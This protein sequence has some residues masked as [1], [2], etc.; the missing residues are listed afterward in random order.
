MRAP[1]N[2]GPDIIEVKPFTFKRVSARS[3]VAEYG[4]IGVQL[5]VNPSG[6]MYQAAGPVPASTGASVIPRAARIRLG[7]EGHGLSPQPTPEEAVNDLLLLL[8]EF[9]E[10]VGN[11]ALMGRKLATDQRLRS[12]GVGR[13]IIEGDTQFS[14]SSIAIAALTHTPTEIE[15]END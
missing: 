8:H 10:H 1:R 9:T 4:G 15:I 3:W 5:S 6:T 7:G 12:L 13:D 2:V 14:T 11:L